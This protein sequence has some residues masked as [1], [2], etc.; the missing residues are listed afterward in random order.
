MQTRYYT[1]TKVMKHIEDKLDMQSYFKNV[2]STK[3][4]TSVEFYFKPKDVWTSEKYNQKCITPIAA[5]LYVI[6]GGQAHLTRRN[7]MKLFNGVIP[8]IQFNENKSRAID[9]ELKF[10]SILII[11]C[12]ENFNNVYYYPTTTEI[13]N[14]K[15]VNELLM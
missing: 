12:I 3:Y 14:D 11:A 13:V 4:L 7:L 10:Q 8:I 6:G 9:D 2:K 15:T 5:T 1:I